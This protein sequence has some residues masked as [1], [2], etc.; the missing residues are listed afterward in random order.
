MRSRT[1]SSGESV[2]CPRCGV[3]M[4]VLFRNGHNGADRTVAHDIGVCEECGKAQAVLFAVKKLVRCKDFDEPSKAKRE[5]EI[6]RQRRL[7][8]QY[9][10]RELKR[11]KAKYES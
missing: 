8:E 7:D 11:L 4:V 1:F 2:A 6:V 10:R 3:A 9:E 5:A